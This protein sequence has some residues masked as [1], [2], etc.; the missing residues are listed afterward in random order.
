M[1]G[2]YPDDIRM[3][4]HDPRS[5]FYDGPDEAEIEA[6]IEDARDTLTDETASLRAHLT[7][8]GIDHA[9][10]ADADGGD[11]WARLYVGD[12]AVDP[13]DLDALERAL[14]SLE[15]GDEADIGDALE[16]A[17]VDPTFM[18]PDW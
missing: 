12:D 11:V 14:A 15:P 4:D 13:S 8:L 6:E 1:R 2:N 17:A 16:G 3:Y 9:V 5:P 10:C 7:R 18:F